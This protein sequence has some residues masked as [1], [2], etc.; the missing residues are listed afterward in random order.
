MSFDSPYQRTVRELRRCGS[1]NPPAALAVTLALI[2]IVSVS[3][4]F[5]DHW[6]RQGE[7]VQVQGAID[8]GTA[9]VIILAALLWLYEEL[10]ETG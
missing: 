8:L 2:W 9:G 7:Y 4:F 10:R 6:R 1:R 3:V 5:A